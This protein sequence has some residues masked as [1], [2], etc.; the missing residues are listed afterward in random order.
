[1]MALNKYNQFAHE[2]HQLKKCA[3]PNEADLSA[4]IK[5]PRYAQPRHIYHPPHHIFCALFY[6]LANLNAVKVFYECNQ[7]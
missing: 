7:R 2:C 6:I 3:M 1:M 5:I 4:L